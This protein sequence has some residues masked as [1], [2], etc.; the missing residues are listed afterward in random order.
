MRFKN[1]FKNIVLY[2]LLVGTYFLSIFFSCTY[3]FFFFENEKTFQHIILLIHVYNMDK[4]V[5]KLVK[6][7]NWKYIYIWASRWKCTVRCTVHCTVLETLYIGH[8]Y[9]IYIY[10]LLYIYLCLISYV[11][12][13]ERTWNDY[14]HLFSYYLEHIYFYTNL[15][16]TK[17]C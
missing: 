14:S 4:C 13:W 7:V 11:I 2:A 8:I 5:K 9:C 15:L 1:G 17:K 12:F 6:K 16:K 3:F 10:T